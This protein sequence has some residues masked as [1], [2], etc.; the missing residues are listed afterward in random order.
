MC[1][2][3]LND[4]KDADREALLDYAFLE[5]YRLKKTELVERFIQIIVQRVLKK[6]ITPASANFVSNN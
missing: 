3:I 5:A 1:V 2:A 6:G 4:A